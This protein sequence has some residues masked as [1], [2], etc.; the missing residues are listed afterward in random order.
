MMENRIILPRLL[1]DTTSSQSSRKLWKSTKYFSKTLEN[2]KICS[3]YLS[4]KVLTRQNKD[5]E[6]P[7]ANYSFFLIFLLNSYRNYKEKRIISPGLLRVITAGCGLVRGTHCVCRQLRQQR[8]PRGHRGSSVS[9]CLEVCVLK[10]V[11]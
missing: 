10:C 11:S 6:Q 1:A 7:W 4:E 9:V 3:S 8:A 5:L 2:D